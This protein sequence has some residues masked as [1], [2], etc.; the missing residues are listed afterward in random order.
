[1]A[2]FQAITAGRRSIEAGESRGKR[3]R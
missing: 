1:V 3:L 2:H